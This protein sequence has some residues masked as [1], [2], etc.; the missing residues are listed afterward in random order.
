PRPVLPVPRLVSLAPQ[1]RS[2]ILTQELMSLT[3]P[4]AMNM[5]ATI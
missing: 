4:Q 5:I 1:M 3:L 2:E